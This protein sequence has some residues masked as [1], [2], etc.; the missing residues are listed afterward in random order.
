MPSLLLYYL[1][2]VVVDMVKSTNCCDEKVSTE[3]Q[4]VKIFLRR[5]MDGVEQIHRLPVLPIHLNKS[6]RHPSFWT[7]VGVDGFGS[8]D[9]ARFEFR[10]VQL[11][12]QRFASHDPA[13]KQLHHCS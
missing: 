1:V 13:R 9:L 7:F 6:V 11:N 12:F 8:T 4:E 10:N 2:V 3:I 5:M